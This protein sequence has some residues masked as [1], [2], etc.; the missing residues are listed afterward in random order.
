MNGKTDEAS[1]TVSVED[2]QTI[3]RVRQRPITS[4]ASRFW[5]VNRDRPCKSKPAPE[6]EC[7][8][9]RTAAVRVH[10]GR[11]RLPRLDIGW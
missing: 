8:G 3:A 11:R 4:A 2:F 9:H 5:A 10:V 6:E 1:E 7:G